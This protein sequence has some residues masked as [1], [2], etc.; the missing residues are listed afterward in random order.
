MIAPPARE[1][2]ILELHAVH[3]HIGSYHILQGVDFAVRRGEVFMLLGRNGAGKTTTL[4]TIMGLWKASQGRIGFEGRTVSKLPST[5]IARLGVAYVPENMGIFQHLSVRENML[6]AARSARN[7]RELDESRLQRIFGWF[8]PIERF[9]LAPA[10][11]LSGGQKQMLAIGRAIIE[12]RKLIIVD[13]P[14]K[15]LAPA[16]VE[17]LLE[18]FVALRD[19]GVSILMVEQNFTLA[20]RLGD[21]VAVMDSGTIMHRGPMRDLA[22]DDALQDALLGLDLRKRAQAAKA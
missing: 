7:L 19:E 22:A 4:R 2:P 20:R 6:L 17:N 3:T 10:G 16:I 14:S 15:G 12:A 21:S 1:D 11:T 18:A 5:E 13:E 8:P 9:W